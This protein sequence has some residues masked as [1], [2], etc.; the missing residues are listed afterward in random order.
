METRYSESMKKG[1]AEVLKSK[2]KPSPAA[3]TLFEELL[4]KGEAGMTIPDAYKCIF[5]A[6]YEE[7]SGKKPLSKR[8]EQYFKVMQIISLIHTKF[9]THFAHAPKSKLPRLVIRQYI[10]S[11]GYEKIRI[12]DT[13]LMVDGRDLLEYA[14]PDQNSGYADTDHTFI[15]DEMK[16]LQLDYLGSVAHKYI[17]ST[18]F[19]DNMIENIE[20][21][22]D[23]RY[24]FIQF[25]PKKGTAPR[26]D[27]HYRNAHPS[28]ADT[29]DKILYYEKKIRELHES[30]D[31]ELRDKLQ[32]F[33]IQWSPFMFSRFTILP[34]KRVHLRI[35]DHINIRRYVR[36]YSA[37]SDIY[38]LATVAFEEILKHKDTMIF[39][40]EKG[41][42][43]FNS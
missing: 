29:C 3:D 31:P 15:I 1:L 27:D 24:R 37:D 25:D 21:T 11:K 17:G 9:D 13:R 26:K 23:A 8:K 30:L 16:P 10:S 32:F 36:A 35:Q 2:T 34:G 4:N 42:V 41:Y 14:S 33:R 12:E 28:K 7:R 40:L 6:D 5:E 18:K 38:L 22:K 19:R 43:P 39:D 20:T